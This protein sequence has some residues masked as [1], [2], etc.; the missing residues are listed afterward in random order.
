[1]HLTP[2]VSELK[3]VLGLLSYYSRFL[4]GM[5]TTLAPL[6]ALLQKNKKWTWG[7]AQKRAFQA[8]K[9]SLQSSTLLVHYDPT[10][11]LLLTCDASPYSIGA[12]LSH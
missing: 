5:S 8:A 3:S 10:K 4:P 1:M 9:D 6:Y 12:V 2:T 11:P 7:E